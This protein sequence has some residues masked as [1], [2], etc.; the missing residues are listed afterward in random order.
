MRA[1]L[2]WSLTVAV[3]A[4]V[5]AVDT[6]HGAF[7]PARLDDVELLATTP[8]GWVR[9]QG[10]REDVRNE[11]AGRGPTVEE[12]RAGL[13]RLHEQGLR[14]CVMLRWE[15]K[16][17]R[18]FG[19][20]NA[21]VTRP[22]GHLPTD[23][24]WAYER[25]RRLAMLYGSL[26]DA[27]E[28]DNEPDLGFVPEDGANYAAFLK[29]CYLG[30]RRGA[31]EAISSSPSRPRLTEG[32]ADAINGVPLVIMAPMGLP[33]GPWFERFIVNDGLSYTDAFN[34]HYYGYAEDFSG[35]YGA[36]EN[37]VAQSSR[38]SNVRSISKTLPIFVTEIGYG[39]L[40]VRERGTKE[41]RLRQWRW[42]KSVGKQVEQLGI[43][44][45]MAFYLQ[46]H[47][48]RTGL[49]FGLS[50]PTTSPKHY[51]LYARGGWY[52]GNNYFMPVDFGADRPEKWMGGIG[53]RAA[54]GDVTPALA[55]WLAQNRW[56]AS[57]RAW[58]IA[59]AETSPIVIDLLAGQDAYGEHRYNGYF[60]RGEGDEAT[61]RVDLVLYNFSAKPVK[62][63]LQL[64][65]CLHTTHSRAIDLAPMERRVIPAVVT[66][67]TRW[68]SAEH[69]SVE[70]ISDEAPTARFATQF[71]PRFEGRTMINEL[72][73]TKGRVAASPFSQL[74]ATRTLATEEAPKQRDNFC[75]VQHG[76][77]VQWTQ[78][79]FAV[80]ITGRP[81]HK[82]RRVEVEIPWPADWDFAPNK[83]LKMEYRAT[84]LAPR[85]KEWPQHD[86]FM[87]QVRTENGNLYAGAPIRNLREA[88]HMFCEPS[89]N[90]ALWFYGRAKQPNE[91]RKNRPVSLLLVF[92]PVALPV[93]YEF[94][95]PALVALAPLNVTSAAR[96]R[97]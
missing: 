10:I 68:F 45:P 40:G 41:G 42:F 90:F 5:W 44:A 78:E 37:A 58:N 72:S 26:V 65:A 35:V 47:H 43:E 34:F 55:W 82:E 30:F 52:S 91:F 84:K 21:N 2:L 97:N 14:T 6:G 38:V 75:W 17:W 29:A 87:I 8:G 83:L 22:R 25:C 56:S 64:P 13:A 93:T 48:E 46:Q 63:S 77:R 70:F 49:E 28:I 31:E 92:Y 32:K 96:G 11:L 76:A 39:M 86:E 94:R 81:P 89:Q 80:T 74:E 69:A 57:K 85:G 16:S 59:A 67:R 95:R 88:W 79:G 27:W 61:A 73:L 3:P 62:G 19:T 54:G 36:F 66:V 4:L 51:D 15:P 18:R 71:Y 23:L 20:N 7:D 53:R 12:T 50:V 9:V 60:V 24:R 33:P 1:C